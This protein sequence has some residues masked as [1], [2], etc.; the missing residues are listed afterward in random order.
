MWRHRT[1]PFN[2]SKRGTADIK[3]YPQKVETSRKKMSV[4]LTYIEQ[5]GKIQGQDYFNV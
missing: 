4:H 2:T 5:T 3:I 1:G